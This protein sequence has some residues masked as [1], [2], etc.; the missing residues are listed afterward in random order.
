MPQF[1]LLSVVTNVLAGLALAGDYLGEKIAFLSS[2]KGIRER[3]GVLIAIGVS[4]A[5]VGILKLIFRSPGESVY[6]AGDLLPALL[7][8]VQGAALL[9]EGF[10]QR[11]ESS[12]PLESV[13]K[14]VLT[15]RV[16]LGIAGMVVAFLHFL[17]PRVLFL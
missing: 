17:M 6:V 7:G 5:V 14:A 11:V 10:R 9:A 12:E 1:Y 16:P 3:R 2:W 8:I 13:S 15:Y 4:A